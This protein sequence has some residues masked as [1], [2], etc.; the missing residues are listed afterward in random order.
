MNKKLFLLIT[1]L[2]ITLLSGAVSNDEKIV[3]SS[4][5]PKITFLELGSTTCIPCIKMKPVLESIQKKYKD[6]IEVIFIDIV[7]D[8]ASARKYKIKVMPTQIFLDE[9]GEEIHRHIGY[10]PE[11]QID[12]FLLNHGLVI[13]ETEK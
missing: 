7:K 6:Q 9:N 12:E 1:L 3:E 5:K 11:E 4:N 2:Y 13:A 10:Y 8:R